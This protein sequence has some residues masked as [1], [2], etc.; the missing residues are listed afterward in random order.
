VPST[1]EAVR[2][3]P[4]WLKPLLADPRIGKEA[5]ALW[6][7]HQAYREAFPTVVE[8]RAFKQLFPAGPEEAKQAL[9]RA[10][11]V[12]EFDNAYY[13]ADARTHAQLAANLFAENPRV[14]QSMLSQ[15]ARVLAERDP[16]SFRQLAEQVRLWSSPREGRASAPAADAEPVALAREREALARQ[17]EELLREQQE[18][19]AAQYAGFQQSAHESV[20]Q[21]MR[22]SIE[23]MLEGGL[24]GEVSD[25]ARKRMAEDIYNEVHAT[26]QA[27]RALTRQVAGILREWRFDD[28]TRQQVVNL[29]F[30]R[31]KTLLPGVA[32]RVVS[33]WTTSVLS[34]NRQKAMKQQAAASRVDIV[35][36][37]SPE[38]IGRR[39]RNSR[40]IDY[41]R[42]SDE[43]ILNS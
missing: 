25:G 11:A 42:M 15:A 10:E 33:D 13:S 37:G 18:F 12:A 6:E 9:A 28:A 3:A 7:Q 36:G 5:Q 8:A 30:G 4:E 43:E 29:I 34:A 16:G 14:F 26:L 19:R 23:Q 31:A 1:A 17:R 32:R 22:Q 39:A 20:V 40:E 35:G 24:P 38:P 41:S 2:P 27:D 21:Q